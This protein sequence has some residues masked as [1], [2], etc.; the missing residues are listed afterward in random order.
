M[1]SCDL[2]L[3]TVEVSS[4][5]QA[6]RLKL[7]TVSARPTTL[8]RPS[9]NSGL[10]HLFLL[11]HSTPSHLH[12]LSST[13]LLP[14]G[15]RSTHENQKLPVN[16]ILVRL[17]SVCLTSSICGKLIRISRTPSLVERSWMQSSRFYRS[18]LSHS[19]QA[20]FSTLHQCVRCQTQPQQDIQGC[21]KADD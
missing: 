6:W 19:R 20:V 21:Q 17:H 18:T 12:I 13:A 8:A 15:Q 11:F 16:S 2:K 14:P 7:N 5:S 4:P 3:D 10:S 1:A 9:C